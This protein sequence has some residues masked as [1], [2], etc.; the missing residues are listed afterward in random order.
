MSIPIS[1]ILETCLY[2][3][4][5][6]AAKGFYSQILK[7]E[8]VNEEPGRHLFFKCGNSMLLVFHPRAT[9]RPAAKDAIDV[10]AHGH[11]GQGHAAFAAS[12]EGLEACRA[13]LEAH[14]IWIE[15]TIDWPNGARSIYFRDP[16]GNSLEIATP[17]LWSLDAE[18]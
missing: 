8:L 18:K 6:K 17:R 1:G 15:R 3:E 4:D 14:G 10:P 13:H 2:A 16:A 5:L 7:L 9:Q 12:A 11:T